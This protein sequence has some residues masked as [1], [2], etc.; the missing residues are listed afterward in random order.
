MSPFISVDLLHSSACLAA[1]RPCFASARFHPI[2]TILHF[3]ESFGLFSLTLHTCLSP[4]RVI[5]MS[6]CI[7][8]VTRGTI[9]AANDVQSAFC[10][11]LDPDG[12]WGW[13]SWLHLRR[14]EAWHAYPPPFFSL[15]K[16]SAETILSIFQFSGLHQ[17][18]HGHSQ[19]PLYPTNFIF[20]RRLTAI[21]LHVPCFL[22]INFLYPFSPLLHGGWFF[23]FLSSCHKPLWWASRLMLGAHLSR[24][25]NADTSLCQLLRH[26]SLWI[27]ISF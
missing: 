1:L 14:C 18:K 5:L 17:R 2:P 19:Y 13:T 25:N 21:P 3:F 12:V 15:L 27:S 26:S 20:F 16:L 23:G 6:A 7:V 24:R 11:L 10:Y 4:C 9:R 22:W 8:H